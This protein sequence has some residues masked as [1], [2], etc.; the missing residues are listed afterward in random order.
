MPAERDP[1]LSLAPGSTEGLARASSNNVSM[2]SDQ[3]DLPSGPLVVRREQ[4]VL[5]AAEAVG[6][7]R[8]VVPRQEDS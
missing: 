6:R 4:P 3:C 2:S 5:L 1:K 8:E 7:L